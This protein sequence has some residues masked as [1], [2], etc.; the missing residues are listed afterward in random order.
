M[1][2]TLPQQIDKFQE[3]LESQIEP[4]ETL[5]EIEIGFEDHPYVFRNFVFAFSEAE[6]WE[7]ANRLEALMRRESEYHSWLP[8][9]AQGLSAASP[10]QIAVTEVPDSEI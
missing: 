10:T 9:E 4:T 2:P 3:I 7:S 1:I 5:W 6:A 8:E